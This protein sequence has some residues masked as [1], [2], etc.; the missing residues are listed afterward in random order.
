MRYMLVIA[1]SVLKED[2]GGTIGAENADNRHVE[3]ARFVVW[4]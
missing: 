3:R 4:P 2:H 1:T